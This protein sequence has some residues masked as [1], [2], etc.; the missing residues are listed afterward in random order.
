MKDMYEEARA[1]LGLECLSV[2]QYAD[3]C[4]VFLHWDYER[5]TDYGSGKTF[6]E[7]LAGALRAAE[8]RRAAHV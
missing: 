6:H 1:K 4:S 8:T 2:M 5:A 3:R 7:A